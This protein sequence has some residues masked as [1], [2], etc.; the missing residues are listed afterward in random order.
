MKRLGLALFVAG[1]ALCDNRPHKGA[2]VSEHDGT[3][4]M[5]VGNTVEDYF[6]VFAKYNELLHAPGSHTLDVLLR[7][8][9][10]KQNLQLS[11]S[12]KGT[13]SLRVRSADPKHPAVFVGVQVVLYGDEVTVEDL[14]LRGS[15]LDPPTLDLTVKSKVTIRRCVITDNHRPL[16]KGGTIVRLVPSYGSPPKTAVIED[17]WFGR[18][19]ESQAAQMIAVS[20]RSAPDYFKSIVF[21]RT[22]FVDNKFSAGVWSISSDEVRFHDCMIVQRSGALVSLDAPK[23]KMVIDGSVLVLDGWQMVAKES[24]PITIQNS[25]V[26]ADGAPPSN[27]K[28]EGPSSARH[29]AAAL[30]TRL[31]KLAASPLPPLGAALKKA[32]AP[33]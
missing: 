13:V 29:D 19:A 6:A 8:G 14:V 10:Y 20:P 17:S 33:H 28:L 18:N 22:T 15:H 21:E 31:E 11:D 24:T 26:Y 30:V 32:L 16:K 4:T 25:T 2:V 3:V 12:M 5:E 7:P 1:A 27:I 9:E 23:T